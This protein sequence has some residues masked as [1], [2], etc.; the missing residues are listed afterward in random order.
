MMNPSLHL[1]YRPIQANGR[2]ASHRYIEILPS[3]ELRPYVACYWSSEP[4]FPPDLSADAADITVVDRVL[5]DGCT[6]IIFEQNL[7]DHHYQIRYCGMFDHPFLLRYDTERPV[8]SFGVRFFPGGSYSFIRASMAE[9]SNRHQDLDGIWPG[10]AGQ[11]GER[12]MEAATLDAKVQVME[13]F[14]LTIAMKN[15][16]A[17]DHLT[18]NLLHRIFA[19]MGNVKVREL[20]E[21]EVVSARQLNRKFIERIGFSPKTFCDI[22]RFQ[23]LVCDLNVNREADMRML[24]LERGF[25]DQAHMIHDFK[26]FYGETPLIAARE[27]RRM[28][29]FY[30]PARK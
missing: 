6:D 14:L 24:A 2:V 8:R 16:M 12:I 27:Y 26:R 11:I 22:V 25:F 5:P 15:E 13:R 21:K 17:A 3:P 18:A 20:A 28:S 29:D 1:L 30:N 9:F 7:R 19:A 23:T 4:R 10:I